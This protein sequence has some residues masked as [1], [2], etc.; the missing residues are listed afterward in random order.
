M[1]NPG[2]GG[3]K[4]LFGLGLRYCASFGQVTAY[5]THNKVKLTVAIM[6]A[7]IVEVMVRVRFRSMPGLE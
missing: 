5:V 4:F 3:K 1:I 7:V 2:T 6:V